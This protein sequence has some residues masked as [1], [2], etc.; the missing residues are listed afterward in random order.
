MRQ[1]ALSE[2]LHCADYT[3]DKIIF[4]LVEIATVITPALTPMLLNYARQSTMCDIVIPPSLL[5]SSS[6]FKPR[7]RIRLF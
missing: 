1:K 6:Q 7:I 3:T 5:L 4:P 2:K